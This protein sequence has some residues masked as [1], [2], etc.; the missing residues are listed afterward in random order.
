MFDETGDIKDLQD[1]IGS[2]NKRTR[3]IQ[4]Q[5]LYE[6]GFVEDDHDKRNAK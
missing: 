3:T 4:R 1:A 6:F 5:T 2:Q